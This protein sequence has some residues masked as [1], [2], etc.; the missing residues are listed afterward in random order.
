MSHTRR[1]ALSCSAG[2][3][4]CNATMRAPAAIKTVSV[5]ALAAPSNSLIFGTVSQMQRT[6][7]LRICSKERACS[8]HG[9]GRSLVSYWH[10]WHV[11]FPRYVSYKFDAL[12]DVQVL[13][14]INSLSRCAAKMQDW[15]GPLLDGMPARVQPCGAASTFDYSFV[16]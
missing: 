16:V 1:Q 6:S 13:I 8:R 14:C 7:A 3:A 5:R 10:Y 11:L 12:T 2:S 9:F 15:V 4:R